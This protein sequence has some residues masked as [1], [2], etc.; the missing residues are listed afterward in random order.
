MLSTKG[1]GGR[2]SS[3]YESEPMYVTDQ[4]R[5][6]NAVGVISSGKTPRE[7]LAALHEIEAALGRDR[8]REKRMG[9]RT[10]DL[11][12]L[13]CDHIVMDTPELTIPHPRMAERGFVLIPLLE[14]APDLRDPATGAPYARLLPG[15]SGGVYSYPPPVV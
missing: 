10:V 6:L 9:P 15:A 8:G 5:F 7:M 2:L 4:P 14:L 12:I 1:T 13:L 3:L 11:D